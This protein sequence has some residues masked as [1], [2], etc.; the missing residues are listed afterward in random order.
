MLKINLLEKR[1]TTLLKFDSTPSEN[2]PTPN[3]Q[4][5][6]CLS[7]FKVDSQVYSRGRRPRCA[8]TD[9][10]NFVLICNIADALLDYA[11]VIAFLATH[12][13]TNTYQSV[14]PKNRPGPARPGRGT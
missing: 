3:P 6:L 13:Q 7:T 14:K 4:V 10:L 8:P 5:D 12:S 9:W 1:Q 2:D 11:K